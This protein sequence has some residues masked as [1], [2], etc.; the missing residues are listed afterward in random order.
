MTHAVF[1]DANEYLGLYGSI[2]GKK[3]LDL[4][5]GQKSNIF[6]PKQVVDEVLRNKLECSNRFFSEQLKDIAANKFP[7]PDHLLGIDDA[8]L[9]E[10]RKT[11]QGVE[12]VRKSL[13]ALASDALGRISRSEDDVSKRLAGLFDKAVEASEEELQRARKRKERGNPPGKPSDPLGDQISWEQLLTYV[14][15]SGHKDIWLITRDTDY[16]AKTDKGVLLLNPLLNLDLVRVCGGQL[17]IHCYEDLS[18]GLIDFAKAVGV[19]TEK[20][21]TEKEVKQIKDEISTWIANTSFES[22]AMA[23]ISK[24]ELQQRFILRAAAGTGMERPVRIW[25]EDEM[26]MIGNAI[27]PN[28]DKPKSEV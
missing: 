8:K 12:E 18:D 27:L 7:I 4:L 6:V 17:Q 21:P 13:R 5:E 1:V 24:A 20:L 11:L 3:L 15:S 22:A 2:A 25:S 26:K 28:Q 10:Y 23:A 14:Q 19:G 16:F 9:T